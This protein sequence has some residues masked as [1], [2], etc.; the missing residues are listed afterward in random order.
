MKNFLYFFVF[1]L[2]TGCNSVSKDDTPS[3]PIV[4][5]KNH[6]QYYVNESPNL[7]NYE[8]L[9]N[10][11]NSNGM[12]YIKEIAVLQLAGQAIFDNISNNGHQQKIQKSANIK[13]KNDYPKL[14][15]INL[16][17]LKV[18]SECN[19]LH[20]NDIVQSHLKYTISSSKKL[21]KLS[22][23]NNIND[24]FYTTI[25]HI[26]EISDTIIYSNTEKLSLIMKDMLKTNNK[27]LRKLHTISCEPVQNIKYRNDTT[28][29]LV[30]GGICKRH[31]DYIIVKSISNDIYILETTLLKEHT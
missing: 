3:K 7:I 8:P 11:K 12:V 28:I 9:Q 1:S 31:S 4:L 14:L 17:D 15:K 19:P 21:F 29:N 6:C 2:L 30:R 22:Q 16:D 10:F 18:S 25:H 5:S 20:F 26:K 23:K 13:L 27:I 24:F